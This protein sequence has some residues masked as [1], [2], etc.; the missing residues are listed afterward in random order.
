MQ[1]T[2]KSYKQLQEPLSH[3]EQREIEKGLI[4]LTSRQRLDSGLP[5]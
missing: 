2:Q 3:K 5:T 4:Y 1:A